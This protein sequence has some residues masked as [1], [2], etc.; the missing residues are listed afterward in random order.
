MK[1]DYFIVYYQLY[2]QLRYFHLFK[3]GAFF[4]MQ[5]YPKVSIVVLNWNGQLYLENCLNSL[6]QTTYPD[7]EIIVVDNASTDGSEKIVSKFKSV[8]LVQSTKNLG[9]AGGNNIGF[10]HATG[11]Y[12]VALNNDMLVEPDWLTDPIQ[13]MESDSKIGICGC[14]QMRFDKTTVDGLFQILKKDLRSLAVKAGEPYDHE[15]ASYKAGYVIGVNGGSAIYRKNLLD[16]LKGFDEHFFG[17]YE[18]IDICMRA[19]IRGWKILYVPSAVVYHIGSASFKKNPRNSVY[20]L[21]RNR[22]WFIYKNFSISII[23]KHLFFIILYEIRNFRGSL[24]GFKDPG[25][26]FKARIDAFKGFKN[27]SSE[28]KVNTRLFYKIKHNFLELS[29]KKIIPIK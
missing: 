21:E 18:D 15:C 26:Y 25:L 2:S 17:Y 22:F 9:Y 29:R 3:V 4:K 23:L 16:D 1:L 28:R 13:Y 5:P 11:K 8:K 10:T 19:F 7:L 20:L 14:R 12:V 24:F 27:L 6:L